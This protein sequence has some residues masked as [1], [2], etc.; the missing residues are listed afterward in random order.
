MP[1]G[2][3]IPTA[4]MEANKNSAS[5]PELRHFYSPDYQD[6]RPDPLTTTI[7]IEPALS[8]AADLLVQVQQRRSIPT[9]IVKMVRLTQLPSETLHNILQFL[10]PGDLFVVLKT[11]HFFYELIKD[12]KVL[13]RDIYYRVLV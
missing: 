10:Y 9:S 8:P 6:L 11:C 13:H 5:S 7:N 1:Q 12:N 3:D 4:F 2:G